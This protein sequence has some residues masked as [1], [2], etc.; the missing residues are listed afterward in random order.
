[1]D[2]SI[3]TLLALWGALL[4]SISL[5]VIIYRGLR[6]KGKVQV[7]CFIGG[8]IQGKRT[9]K[10]DYLVF[11]ITNSSNKTVVIAKIGATLKKRQ[12]A[13]ASKNLPQKLHPGEQVTEYTKDLS[14]FRHDG[15][16]YLWAQDAVGHIWKVNKP[17]MERLKEYT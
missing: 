12:F 11:R 4:S 9:S 7:T 2:F 1:M 5:W 10:E 3:T 17:N 8:L 15:L 13:V 14:P 16:K 6:E